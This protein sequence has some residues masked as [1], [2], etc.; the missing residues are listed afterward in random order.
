MSNSAG[1]G[2]LTNTLMKDLTTSPPGVIVVKLFLALN[3]FLSITAF[4]GNVLILIALHRVTSIYPPTKLF[5]RCLAVT[6]L[7]VGLITQP[8]F[9]I[10]NIFALTKVNR[11]ILYY[12]Y[13]Y[14]VRGVSSA[15]L[16]GLSI[17]TSTAIS[18]DRLLAVLLKLRY[19]HVVTLTRVR[20]VMICFLFICAL[21]TMIWVWKE[22]I[23][24][25]ASSVIIVLSLVTSISSYV[26]IHL[27][28]RK[29]QAQ[30]QNHVSQRQLNGGGSPLNIARYK[31]T[32]SSI[33]WVQLALV[34]CYVPY[35]I[36]AGIGI[37]N[38][39]VWLA[40]STLIFLN[41]SLNPILYCWKIREVRRVVKDTIRQL[42][43]C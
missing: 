1:D 41:S 8:L 29:Q 3:M 9:T 18:V 27:E 43:C 7:S 28:L 17:L 24:Y 11:N 23:F 13:N 25:K 16:C 4:L 38:G 40:T 33:L 26:K 22:D 30:I 5:F 6:D 12:M 32:V 19:N 14:N 21:F 39:V 31:K 10:Y 36:V 2:N 37:N 34:V 20:I 42:Y 15:V 35:V